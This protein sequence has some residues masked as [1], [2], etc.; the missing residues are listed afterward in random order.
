MRKAAELGLL[1][2]NR[3]RILIGEGK[4]LKLLQGSGGPHFLP[5]HPPTRGLFDSEDGLIHG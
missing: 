3:V 4:G 5:C 2:A 1:G